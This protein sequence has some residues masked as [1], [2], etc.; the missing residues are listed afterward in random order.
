MLL[1]RFKVYMF[2][3]SEAHHPRGLLPFFMS[4]SVSDPELQ[5][6]EFM[7]TNIH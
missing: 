5:S 6:S 2:L 1:E 3:L 4:D 7:S